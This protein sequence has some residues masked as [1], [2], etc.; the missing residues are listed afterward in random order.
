LGEKMT[1]TAK[2]EMIE[3]EE[4]D[5][6]AVWITLDNS[7]AD[8]CLTFL[9]GVPKPAVGKCKAGQQITATGKVYERMDAWWG[10]EKVTGI[11]CK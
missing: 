11:S 1:M 2:I 8:H 3:P 4:D 6:K 10:L 7:A 9:T 5:P